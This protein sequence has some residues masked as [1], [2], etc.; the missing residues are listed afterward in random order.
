[1]ALAVDLHSTSSQALVELAGQGTIEAVAISDLKFDQNYQRDIRAQFV[2]EMAA[3]YDPKVAGSIVCNRRGNGALYVIDGQHRTAAAKTAGETH[4]LAVVFEGLTKAQ[5]AAM[6]V[7]GNVRQAEHP[8]ERWRA[9]LAAGD[10]ESN[11]IQALCGQYGTKINTTPTDSGINCV[12]T[13]EELYRRDN[14][15]LL[16][17][18]F[19]IITRAWGSPSG[20]FARAD[21]I[22]AIAHMLIV[23][24][25]E[26]DRAR[27]VDVLQQEGTT[28]VRMKANALRATWGGSGNVNWYRALVEVYNTGLPQ[29]QR[30]HPRIHGRGSE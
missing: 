14:G 17:Q 18:V 25:D 1:M 7:N 15:E 4:M 21:V 13:I 24:G 3:N 16:G 27:L 11:A 8:S 30:V 23:N 2:Q 20:A 29:R 12:S 28:G 10:P 19:D 6:R 26:I 9:K 5:E 22:K